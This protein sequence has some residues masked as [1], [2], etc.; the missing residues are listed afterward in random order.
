MTSLELR[1]MFARQVPELQRMAG[2]SFR[3]MDPERRQ[4]A[5]QNSIALAWKQFSSLIEQGRAEPK[6]VRSCLGF[7]IR[8]TRSGRLPQ[9]KVKAKDITEHR[10]RG[11]VTFEQA[12]LDSFVS[13]ITPIPD[14]VIFRLDVP[15]FLSRLSD[16]QQR[17][18][19]DLM[20]GM[21]TSEVAEKYKVTLP[22]VSQFR[23]R[24]AQLFE[25]FLA[26]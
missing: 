14:Q 19:T 21:T 3:D 5:I 15:A 24:F 26:G 8:Q 12:A 9:G 13:D 6:H 25:L 20:V 22:A 7:G 17:M 10:R 2:A 4:E 16:R 18:A 1:E 11:G 23:R